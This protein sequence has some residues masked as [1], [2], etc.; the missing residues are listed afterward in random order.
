MQKFR[1]DKESFLRLQIKEKQTSVKRMVKE[2]KE[3][4][5]M[6]EITIR[7]RNVQSLY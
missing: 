6:L 1:K 4:K 2:I 3:L 7:E 5:R